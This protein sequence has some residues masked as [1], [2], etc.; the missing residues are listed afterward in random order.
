MLRCTD[1]LTWW[2]VAAPIPAISAETVSKTFLPHWVSPFGVPATVT[3]DHGCQF[4]STLFRE[5]TYLLGS[6][7]IRTTAYHPQ[8]NGLV[9]SFHQQLK[10]SLMSQPDNSQWYDHLPL[11]LLAL[12]STLKAGIGCTEADIVYR[13]SIRLPGELVCPSSTLTSV[14]PCGYAGQLRSVIRNLCA[15]PPRASA[16]HS[17]IPPDLDKCNFFLVWHD[18]VRRPLRPPYNGPYKVLRRRNKDVVIDRNP[19]TNTDSIDQV[20]PAY[21]DDS[22]H[23][24][25]QHCTPPQ[26]V[27]PPPTGDSPPPVRR[28][29]YGRHAH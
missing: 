2:P 5:L 7:R 28:T 27:M 20:K 21:I 1:R 13:T 24:S 9:E 19:E 3:T 11:V 18:A 6:N 29:Q 22:D 26:T 10:T 25:H 16:T 8:A 14:E 12:R 17:F 23:S 15:T 4:E